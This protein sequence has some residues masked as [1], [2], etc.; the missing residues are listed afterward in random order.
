M[1][2]DIPMKNIPYAISSK[3]LEVLSATQF[4]PWDNTQYKGYVGLNNMKKGD[5][6]ELFVEEYMKH[7][8]NYVERRLNCGHDRIIDG[9]KTEIKFSLNSRDKNG[10]SSSPSNNF[11]FN[12]IS[13]GKDWDRLILCG[14]NLDQSITIVWCTK[15]NLTTFIRQDKHQDIV[16]PQQGGKGLENDDYWITGPKA[17][18][19]FLRL[20]FIHD[21]SLWKERD[22]D[23]I[24]NNNNLDRFFT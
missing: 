6:G 19:K 16:K 10:I 4:D 18:R 15:A 7:Q 14:I 1:I 21:I 20:D 23:I 12:H 8:L 9:Y 5:F 3:L 24:H 17:V 13:L 2:N 22:Y 11:I